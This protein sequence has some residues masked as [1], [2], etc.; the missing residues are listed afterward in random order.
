MALASDDPQDGHGSLRRYSLSLASKAVD[1][2]AVTAWSCLQTAV[3]VQA[4]LLE[5]VD[6]GSEPPDAIV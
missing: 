2:I 4:A 3:D 1:C 6:D 5:L